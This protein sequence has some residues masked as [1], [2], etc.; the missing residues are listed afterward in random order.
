MNNKNKTVNKMVLTA[1]MMCMT[2]VMTMIIRIPVP[3]TQGYIHLGD[4][5]I[6]F[7]VLLLGWKWGA[8]AAGV[9]S[10]MAD[11]F[12]GYVQ[13]IPITFI[14]KGLMA[15]VM[16]LFIDFAVKHGFE[17]IKMRIAEIFGMVL[18][19]TFMVCGYYVAEGFM[20]GSFIT[21]L[22]SIPMNIVQFAT[23]V[24]LA[25]L[26]AYALCK[27]PMKNQFAYVLKS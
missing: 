5:M 27:T 16:G 6:F 24:V 20:Y 10:A 13:Y 17:G 25:L 8:V 21:P 12:A 3:A 7:S 14:V 22:A 23:G 2:V 4:C 11:M 18:G 9:G 19:G 26:L 15:V 1:M